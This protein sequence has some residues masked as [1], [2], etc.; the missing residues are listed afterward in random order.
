MNNDTEIELTDFV[1]TTSEG[2]RNGQPPKAV[3][4]QLY[5]LSDKLEP[6]I[7][8]IPRYVYILRQICEWK[9]TQ[10]KHYLNQTRIPLTLA[11]DF[12]TLK[13]QGNLLVE[14]SKTW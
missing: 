5:Q 10:W 13:Y 14:T 11:W 1:N 6:L 3:V 8:D 7:P 2:P 4:V 12:T 9:K